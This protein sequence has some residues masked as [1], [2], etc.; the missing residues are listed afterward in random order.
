MLNLQLSYV[1]G[2]LGL[3]LCNS[4]QVSHE[5]SEQEAIKSTLTQM[6]DAIEQE[7]VARYATFIHPDFTQFGETDS[8]LRSGKEREVLGVKNWVAGSDN[9][10][11]EM[12]EPKVIVRGN[13]A[14]ITYYWADSGFS[15]ET[16]FASRGK[17]TRIFVKENNNWLCIHGHY[18]LLPNRKS[19]LSKNELAIYEQREKSNQALANRSLEEI[20]SFWTEDIL[21]TTGNGTLLAGKEKIKGFL[22][23]VYQKMPE[24]VYERTALDLKINE[25]KGLAWESGTWIGYHV[26]KKESA[27]ARGNYSAM[28]TEEGAGWKI[29]SQLFVEL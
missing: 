21:I 13:T 24:V 11:T 4:C 25:K 17:S 18:T 3:I 1:F 5:L 19:Q 16:A 8:I 26:G 9:I 27:V 12:E 7:D 15:G 6:W 29:K 22:Q 23:D 10:H 20:S 2:L 28:W 14:W